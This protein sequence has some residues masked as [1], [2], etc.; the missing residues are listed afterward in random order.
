MGMLN[1][2]FKLKNDD[3]LITIADHGNDPTYH[4]IDHTRRI[5]T[6]HSS[7]MDDCLET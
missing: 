3:L 1:K 5:C 7:Y 6:T 4:G 2:S